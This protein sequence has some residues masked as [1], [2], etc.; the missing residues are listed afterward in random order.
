MDP[1]AATIARLCAATFGPAV[2]MEVDI[3]LTG[4]ASGQP[5]RTMSLDTAI[6]LANLIVTVAGVAW[7]IY[8]DIAKAGGKPDASAIA[9]RIED[10]IERNRQLPALPAPQR[11]AV[12]QRAAEATIKAAAEPRD[13]P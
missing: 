4:G 9:V 2:A 3:Q 10:Q 13:A 5:R 12:I 1:Q 7:Q 8:R 11:E 6:A